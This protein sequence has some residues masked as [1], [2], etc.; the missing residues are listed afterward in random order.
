MFST[1]TSKERRGE[2]GD[3]GGKMDEGEGGPKRV[4]LVLTERQ[5][6]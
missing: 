6:F 4:R 1:C 3:G 2:G 5:Q